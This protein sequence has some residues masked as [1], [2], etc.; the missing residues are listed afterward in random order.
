[1]SD[2]RIACGEW[3]SWS[4]CQHA[5]LGACKGRASI[6][7]RA[8]RAALRPFTLAEV[9]RNITCPIL[10]THGE[11]DIIV[12]VTVAHQLYREVSSKDKELRIFNRSEGGSEHCQIDAIQVGLAYMADRM[13][14]HL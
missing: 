1:M 9:A 8:G 6:R 13:A 7:E 2:F 3:P 12:P 11:D 4:T 10:I 14:E 5:D